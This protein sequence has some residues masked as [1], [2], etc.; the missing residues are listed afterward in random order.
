M[1]CIILISRTVPEG[2]LLDLLWDN[3]NQD[4]TERGFILENVIERI[5]YHNT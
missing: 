1:K 2:I 3:Q 5:N 4:R